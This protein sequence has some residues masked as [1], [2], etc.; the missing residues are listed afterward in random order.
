MLFDEIFVLEERRSQ[1]QYTCLGTEDAYG[2][3]VAID[4][5]RTRSVTFEKVTSCK[6]SEEF[7]VAIKDQRSIHHTLTHE[8]RHSVQAKRRA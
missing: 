5:E 7:R 8:V 2:K 3:F 1:C 6:R 4:G